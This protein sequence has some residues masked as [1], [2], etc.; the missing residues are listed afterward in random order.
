MLLAVVTNLHPEYGSHMTIERGTA[1]Q[2]E[3]H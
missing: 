1:E 3:K 2:K